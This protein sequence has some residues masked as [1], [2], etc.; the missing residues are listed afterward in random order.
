[1]IMDR[2]KKTNRHLIKLGILFLILMTIYMCSRS[3]FESGDTLTFRFTPFS[4]LNEFNFDLDEFHGHF[5]DTYPW[6]MYKNGS[7]E[8]IPY[9][10]I[11]VKRHYLSTFGIGPAIVALPV[12]F[13]PITIFHISHE[14]QAAIFLARLTAGLLIALSSIF[15]Y[16]SAKLIS[17]ERKA[18]LITFIY[19]LC[20]GMWSITSQQLGQQTAS[21]FFLAMSVYFLIK[22]T[23]NSKF[24]PYAGFSLASAVLMR[25]TNI[26]TMLVLT[27]YVLHRYR[28]KFWRYILWATPVTL[29]VAG[30]NYYHH[31]SIFLFSQAIYNP[32]GALYKT[33]SPDMWSTP[34][35]TGLLGTL[36]SPSRGL[37]I[38][39]PV[40]I[41]SFIGMILVWTKSKELIFKYFSATV[42][43][44][45][46]V[47]SK[48]Y[49]WWGGWTFGCRV[50]NDCI[51]FLSI[52]M[53]PAIDSL[54]AKKKQV[55]IFILTI[56]ISFSIQ[57]V[58]AFLYNNEWNKT[59]DIDHH[60]DRLW[61][62]RNS[63][64]VHYLSFKKE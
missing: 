41:F 3:G 63:Q 11:K 35:L 49:D 5:L 9:Y 6:L 22:G 1:M 25:P 33:G 44:L 27:V 43:I 61:S 16:L 38:Y 31:G 23:K 21:E 24:I 19:A 4:I 34:M 30:Y 58:G 55:S 36:I 45:I 17:G 28:H 37:F 7:G 2:D 13:F 53:I 8:A 54:R 15:I 56:F 48:W 52:L 64:L 18:W 14:S 40:F 26:L 10:L 29:F 50:L 12:F 47:H 42:I 46:M 57:A 32:M 60:Q 51:P 59:P 39:S 20:S 62:W